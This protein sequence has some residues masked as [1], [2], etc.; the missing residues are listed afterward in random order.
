[1][2]HTTHALKTSAALTTTNQHTLKLKHHFH[3]DILLAGQKITGLYQK[4]RENIAQSLLPSSC[5]ST[6]RNMLTISNPS[7]AP[8]AQPDPTDFQQILLDLKNLWGAPSL[9]FHSCGPSQYIS[10]YFSHHHLGDLGL[11]TCK[12]WQLIGSLVT[13]KLAWYT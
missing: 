9:E 6:K 1:M 3:A 13:T 7:A 8:S 2:A 12:Q 4:Q 5:S 11:L 10:V